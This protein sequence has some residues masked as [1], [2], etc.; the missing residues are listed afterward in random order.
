MKARTYKY[1]HI[2]EFMLANPLKTPAEVAELFNVGIVTVYNIRKRNDYQ[3]KVPKKKKKSRVLQYMGER[4]IDH[5][6]K[7]K[8]LV[9]FFVYGYAIEV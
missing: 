8:E 9:G 6:I 2:K 5:C 7:L 1:D 4:D 3:G